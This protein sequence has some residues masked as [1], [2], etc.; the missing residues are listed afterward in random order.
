MT[1]S[2]AEE[3]GYEYSGAAGWHRPKPT[4]RN[5]EMLREQAMQQR[6]ELSRIQNAEQ[7]SAPDPARLYFV[8]DTQVSRDEYLNTIALAQIKNSEYLGKLDRAGAQI[9]EAERLRE[10]YQ[11]PVPPTNNSTAGGGVAFVKSSPKKDHNITSNS[12]EMMNHSGIKNRA[13]IEDNRS[14]GVKKLTEAQKKL[15]SRPLLNAMAWVQKSAETLKERT[16]SRVTNPHVEKAV[17]AGIDVGAFFPTVALT[18]IPFVEST[19]RHPSTPWTSIKEG[20]K[21][22]YHGAIQ[23]PEYAAYT[24]V[25]GAATGAAAGRVTAKA[26]APKY[27]VTGVKSV[28]PEV[29]S[30]TTKTGKGGGTRYSHQAQYDVAM[31]AD[32]IMARMLGRAPK[33]EI[34]RV[35]VDTAGK[36][37]GKKFDLDTIIRDAQSNVEFAR[38]RGQYNIRARIVK[39][40][41]AETPAKATSTEHGVFRQNTEMD[42]YPGRAAESA[43]KISAK[44]AKRTAS[45][46][47]LYTKNTIRQTAGKASILDEATKAVFSSIDDSLSAALARGRIRARIIDTGKAKIARTEGTISRVQSGGSIPGGQPITRSVPRQMVPQGQPMKPMELPAVRSGNTLQ[48]VTQRAR[49]TRQAVIQRAEAM[50]QA[51]RASVSYVMRNRPAVN[52]ANMGRI[53]SRILSMQSIVL[54]ALD[55]ERRQ[56]RVRRQPVPAAQASGQMPEQGRKNKVGR[57]QMLPQVPSIEFLVEQGRAPARAPRR[58]QMPRYDV[59]PAQEPVPHQQPAPQLRVPSHLPPTIPQFS[60]SSR[61]RLPLLNP[62]GM[63]LGV[64]GDA[65]NSAQKSINHRMMSAKRFL[66]SL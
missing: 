66:Q 7:R 18:A 33:T 43:V 38:A 51:S 22:V 26:T 2:E 25:F 15:Y 35:A 8:G 6:E 19:I 29:F 48:A 5:V 41:S 42:I 63:Q 49:Q 16:T 54:S 45:S 37:K 9:Q 32:T 28:E 52:T 53:S 64:M 47:I 14:E 60:R 30:I 4:I 39:R 44:G 17:K 1:P 3:Q 20:A 50:R 21:G 11:Y 55:P 61:I 34:Q 24:L 65:V 13:L 31:Q 58:G 40:E 36:F 23:D 10:K 27:K 57:P 56:D 46:K 62:G 59:R 12:T